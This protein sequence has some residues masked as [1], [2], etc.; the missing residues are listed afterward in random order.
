MIADVLKGMVNAL[1]FTNCL[2]DVVVLWMQLE[3]L[4]ILQVVVGWL[5]GWWLRS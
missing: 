4:M 2:L 3:S 5:V 1:T